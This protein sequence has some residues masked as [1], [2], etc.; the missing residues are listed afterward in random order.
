MVA[1]PWSSLAIVFT[2]F[3][4][5]VTPSLFLYVHGNSSYSVPYFQGLAHAITQIPTNFAALGSDEKA[6]VGFC[7]AA[8]FLPSVSIFIA[9]G[10][11]HRL[12]VPRF[13]G[14][15]KDYRR[16]SPIPLTHPLVLSRL[17]NGR[18]IADDIVVAILHLANL[19][20]LEIALIDD[21]GKGSKSEPKILLKNF[22]E[23][24]LENEIDIVVYNF[25]LERLFSQRQE[26][27]LSDIVEFSR[28]EPQDFFDWAC[29]LFY[30]ARIQADESELFSRTLK[31][32][33]ARGVFR[34]K[35]QKDGAGDFKSDPRF[36]ERTGGGVMLAFL[37][38]IPVTIYAI[39]YFAQI[40]LPG[41]SVP[42]MSFSFYL[43]LIPI[44]MLF[45]AFDGF[46]TPKGRKAFWETRGLK[47]WLKDFTALNDSDLDDVT[48]WDQYLV[49]AYILSVSKWD[50]RK[51]KQVGY[52]LIDIATDI[53]TEENG[54][55]PLPFD[56]YGTRDYILALQWHMKR[57]QGE[58]EAK[59]Y[60]RKKRVYKA[61]RE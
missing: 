34:R 30:C 28:Q 43:S 23:S 6:I 16:D 40:H 32:E 7:C 39:L 15:T 55:N 18:F 8:L 35:I 27:K 20:I 59:T 3:L 48:V 2:V 25:L 47:K 31:G 58:G 45:C 4:F 52:S 57:L 56:E 11:T 10:L 12:A 1:S 26:V 54:P 60:W 50:T 5:L 13:L 37:F 42:L 53:F 17:V 24:I 41:T 33:Q 61:E 51:I 44:C 49:Y 19:G 9:F 29:E 36:P 46:R 38:V 21:K 22:D 14:R